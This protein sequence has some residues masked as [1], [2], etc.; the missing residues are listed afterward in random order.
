MPPIIR[1]AAVSVTIFGTCAASG[2]ATLS[3]IG[4]AMQRL[5][6][7]HDISGAVTMVVNKD[8]IAHLGA[9]GFADIESKRP[10]R[11]D[12]IFWIASMTKPVTDVAIMM[13]QDEG[14]LDVDDPVAKYI[15]E[16]A[17]FE[18]PSGAAANLTIRHIL[19]HTSGLA[20]ATREEHAASRQLK[21]LIPHYLA[22]PMQFE[23]GA[24]WQYCQSGIN[25]AGR[26]VEIAS[27]MPVEVFFR[28]KLFEP[29]GMKDTA[30]L[31]APEQL[32]RVAIQFFA[33]APAETDLPDVPARGIVTRFENLRLRRTAVGVEITGL[34]V[35]AGQRSGAKF[36]R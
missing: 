20:E 12:T 3:G 18:T 9:T 24:K 7:S 26:I 35:H 22:K 6:K 2:A 16:F 25:T 4:E 32:S 10:I 21:D 11:D 28:Q 17:A 1:L 14:N 27:G 31:L 19:T 34:G 13:L 15:P 36:S 23:P 33:R 8:G 29:L 30:F 5:V